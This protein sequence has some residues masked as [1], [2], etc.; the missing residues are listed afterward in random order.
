MKVGELMNVLRSYNPEYDF[1]ICS[2]DDVW[3]VEQ[4]SFREA[5]LLHTSNDIIVEDR[6]YN[7]AEDG[8]IVSKREA[9]LIDL[10]V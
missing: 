1:M 8:T 7:P 10:D 3:V 9:L 4:K 2:E 6:G 5:T